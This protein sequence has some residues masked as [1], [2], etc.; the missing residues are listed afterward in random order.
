MINDLARAITGA[1]RADRIPVPNL[2]NMANLPTVNELCLS[3]SATSAWRAS[4]GGP[5]SDLMQLGDIRLRA[6]A[7]QKHVPASTRC[8]AAVNIC[9][10]WNASPDL[11]SATSMA[12]AKKSATVLATKCRYYGVR[13]LEEHARATATGPTTE[14]TGCDLPTSF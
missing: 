12:M 2:L 11:R 7:S 4:L 8:I 13:R 1:K 3:R 9:N 14:W 10:A 6:A 5:C